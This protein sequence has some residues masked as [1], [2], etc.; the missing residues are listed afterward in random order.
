MISNNE[1]CEIIAYYKSLFFILIYNVLGTDIV[2]AVLRGY[3]V[4]LWLDL[5]ISRVRIIFSEL[6]HENLVSSSNI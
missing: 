5:Y 6:I 1:L 3:F 4:L 2:V